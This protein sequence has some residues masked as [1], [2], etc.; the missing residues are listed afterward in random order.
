[1]WLEVLRK[2]GDTPAERIRRIRLDKRLSARLV[3][4]GFEFLDRSI[5][6]EASTAYQ[7][8]LRASEDSAPA[9]ILVASHP[10]PVA[11]QHPPERPKQVEA[12]SEIAGAVELR[13]TAPAQAGALIFRR[14]VLDADASPERLALL[15]PQARSTFVDRSVE[16][17]G[18]YAYQVALAV[19]IGAVDTGAVDTGAVDTGATVQF[20]QPSE[21]IYV[22]V[23]AALQKSH[24]ADTSNHS[25]K[26][27]DVRA[28][29]TL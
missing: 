19:D 29:K 23:G 25:R 3:G 12:S 17:G 4:D 15:G 6:A 7:V 20:G 1:M 2:Q 21:E 9:Q 24:D 28:Q 26:R 5:L 11:W 8:R 27:G 18:V 13:W 10:L 16:P 14:D 22:T